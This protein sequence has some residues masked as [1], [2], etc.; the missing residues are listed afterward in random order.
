MNEIRN[1]Q[2]PKNHRKGTTFT[3]RRLR[4]FAKA[5]Y[6]IGLKYFKRVVMLF[7]ALVTTI[8]FWDILSS[9]GLR[10]INFVLDQ[11]IT[12]TGVGFVA[13]LIALF[14]HTFVKRDK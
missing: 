8:N 10:V 7:C 14:V 5:T 6:E 2:K 13:L 4:L 12:I 1:R 11:F 3:S 9:V